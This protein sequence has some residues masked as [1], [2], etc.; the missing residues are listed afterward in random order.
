M[1]ISLICHAWDNAKT[2]EDTNW[3]AYEWSIS[4]ISNGKI[5][6][7]ANLLIENHIQELHRIARLRSVS[8]LHR[9]KESFR[10]NVRVRN[11]FWMQP[12]L[13]NAIKWLY[14]CKE[15]SVLVENVKRITFT[16][17]VSV[18]QGCILAP[19]LLDIILE[20]LMQA[21][22]KSMEGSSTI[23]ALQATLKLLES[24]LV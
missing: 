13:I 3:T 2:H 6:N 20:Y 8:H 18:R 11:H 19:D 5:H 7:R 22:E 24:H 21:E 4:R 9:L 14:R 16:Q 12:K 1:T 10:S 23:F 17:T 15:I